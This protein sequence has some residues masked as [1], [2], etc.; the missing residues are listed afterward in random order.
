[1]LL[2]KISFILLLFAVAALIQRFVLRG[3][4]AR[5]HKTEQAHR[6]HAIRDELQV[7]EMNG[8]ISSDS[9]T[10]VMLLNMSNFAIKNAGTMRLRDVLDFTPSP[11]EERITNVIQD[12]HMH[13]EDVQKLAGNF[14]RAFGVMIVSNDWI[15]ACGLTIFLMFRH[16]WDAIR[17]TETILRF[18][19][20]KVRLIL[21]V[22]DRGILLLVQSVSPVRAESVDRAREY[23]EISDDLIGDHA[24]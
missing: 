5:I 15:A 22:L 8:K 7:L 13:D 21:K 6:F 3:W 14:F 20:D 10:Y 9:I 16:G 1:M 23:R 11:K 4:S 2:E 18:A 17:P 24:H 12:V 19:F